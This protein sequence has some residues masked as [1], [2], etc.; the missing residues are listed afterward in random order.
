MLVSNLLKLHSSYEQ[1][2]ISTPRPPS[3]DKRILTNHYDV[4]LSPALLNQ[5]HS[6]FPGA[7]TPRDPRWNFPHLSIPRY[8]RGSLSVAPS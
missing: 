4:S 6:F 3:P 5:I 2:R 7:L 8:S 1:L